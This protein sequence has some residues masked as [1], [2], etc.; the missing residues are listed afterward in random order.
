MQKWEYASRPKSHIVDGQ[1]SV[2]FSQEN[3]VRLQLPLDF[4]SP[5]DA[6]YLQACFQRAWI[7]EAMRIASS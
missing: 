5:F 4:D 2:R 3:G 6:C 7:E 1:D